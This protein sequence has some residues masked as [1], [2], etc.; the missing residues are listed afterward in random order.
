[1]AWAL[2]STPRARED[3]AWVIPGRDRGVP[4]RSIT[5]P[6]SC[7]AGPPPSSHQ[8]TATPRRGCWRAGSWS[9]L[10]LPRASPSGGRG[11]RRLQADDFAGIHDA[12][13]IEGELDATHQVE[14]DRRLVA[15]QVI[16]LE[17]ADAMLGADRAAHLH[18]DAVHDV[19]HF[20]PACQE[21]LGVGAHGLADVEMHVAVA[22]VAE[23]HRTAAGHL[24]LDR[25]G[26]A[27]GALGDAADGHGYVVLDA[28]ALELLRLHHRLADA[29]ELLRLLRARRDHAVF[30][31]PG[32]QR[33]GEEGFQPVA[34]PAVGPARGDGE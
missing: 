22:D 4:R 9:L 21:C 14:S 10:A 19:V 6:I 29:P 17:D 20:L 26:E 32:F 15:R 28:A 27:L 16:A 2:S 25:R 34:Q 18:D 12:V 1:M 31:Q 5:F 7:R 23:R 3:A 33:L 24:G 11:L 13:G 30:D 8:W